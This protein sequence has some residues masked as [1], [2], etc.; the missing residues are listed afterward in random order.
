MPVFDFA[1]GEKKSGDN[2][3][4]KKYVVYFDRVSFISIDWKQ[5]IGLLSKLEEAS[6]LVF[7][8]ISEILESL[9]SQD[10]FDLNKSK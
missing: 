7:Q 9:A 5:I 3:S 1:E 6:P 4:V 8:D 10:D 2:P